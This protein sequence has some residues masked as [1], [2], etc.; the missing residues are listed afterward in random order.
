MEGDREVPPR[1]VAGGGTGGGGVDGCKFIPYSIGRR[2]CPGS[3]LAE[4]EM[5][6]AMR[7]LLE[8]EVDE[9]GD[10]NRST[11]EVF[12]YAHSDSIPAAPF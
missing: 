1:A 8:R 5:G 6:V 4:A 2:V 3:C 10:A 12:T 11:G 9:G 7:V